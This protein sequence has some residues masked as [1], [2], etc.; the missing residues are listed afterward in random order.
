MS[1]ETLNNTAKRMSGGLLLAC[2]LLGLFRPAMAEPGPAE[3]LQNMMDTLLEIV[4]QDPGVINDKVRLRS[5]ANEVVLSRVDFNTLS[6][7]VLGKYWRT[8][9]PQ[10]RTAFIAEFREML[11]GSYLNSVSPHDG[12]GVR[13]L[14]VRGNLDEGH[15]I[16]NVEVDQPDG[17]VIH[18]SFRM[19]RSDNE[20]LIFDVAVEG[21]S[22]VAS[23]RTSF[24]REIRES[25]M[26]SLI[27]QLRVK[28]ERR[29]EEEA[30]ARQGVVQ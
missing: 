18:V 26:D 14:P 7:W 25:G 28:N 30:A 6:R 29:S 13:I 3:V 10:Q 12:N 11:V 15:A 23:H 16:V 9:T 19:R 4:E 21:V 8:A 17:P 22:L 2:L 1:M 5:I 27:A 20:W 24:S